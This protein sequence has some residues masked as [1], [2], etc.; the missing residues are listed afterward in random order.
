MI[1]LPKDH[2]QSHHPTRK[3]L[4]P[5]P[6]AL[7]LTK[8]F[9]RSS[10]VGAARPPAREDPPTATPAAALQGSAEIMIPPGPSRLRE[11]RS[12]ARRQIKKARLN[13][14]FQ[15]AYRQRATDII[16]DMECQ[17]KQLIHD[18]SV[19]PI[20]RVRAVRIR[21]TRRVQFIRN[22]L[23]SLMISSSLSIT[24]GQVRRSTPPILRASFPV[25]SLKMKFRSLRSPNEVDKFPRLRD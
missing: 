24:L 18:R 25:N 11:G 13:R 6:L 5:N 14:K 17:I 1:E 15:I 12:R 23:R 7:S 21:R 20:R 19:R 22:S 2:Q 3:G 16:S 8:H 10:A 9:K 4:Y